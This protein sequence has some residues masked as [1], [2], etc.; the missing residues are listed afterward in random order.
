M[1]NKETHPQK[2]I[3]ESTKTQNIMLI[4]LICKQYDWDPN[5][6]KILLGKKLTKESNKIYK[7]VA[8]ETINEYM[9]NT[10]IDIVSTKRFIKDG[11]ETIK[12]K[13]KT[14]KPIILNGLLYLHNLKTGVN[15]QI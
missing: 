12:T 10:T 6:L 1:S 5:E 13:I 15:K 2:D 3:I 8:E 4:N 9:N 14:Y 7:Q 11:K